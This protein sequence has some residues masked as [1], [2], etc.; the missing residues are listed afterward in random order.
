MTTNIVEDNK[1]LGPTALA[2][3]NRIEDSLAD[4]CRE[5]LLDKEDE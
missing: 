2:V 3:A 1:W 4:H 5:K